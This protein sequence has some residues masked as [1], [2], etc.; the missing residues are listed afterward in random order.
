MR[1][2]MEQQSESEDDED[3]KVHPQTFSAMLMP[4]VLPTSL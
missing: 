3:S 1:R 4:L 2:Y